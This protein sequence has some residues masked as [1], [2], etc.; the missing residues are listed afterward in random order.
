MHV[1]GKSCG[2]TETSIPGTF[3]GL[4]KLSPQ[5]L[6]NTSVGNLL[7][8][9]QGCEDLSYCGYSALS[10]DRAFLTNAIQNLHT[11]EVFLCHSFTWVRNALCFQ[12]THPKPAWEWPASRSC[13][14]HHRRGKSPNLEVQ[15]RRALG[16]PLCL[17]DKKSQ[18]VGRHCPW[19]RREKDC[20]GLAYQRESK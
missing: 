12:A 6:D 4:A 19:V 17:E 7:S 1:A 8:R 20:L 16:E 5:T 15:N 11:L 9:H 10:T 13:V 2:W 18:L 3:W 14:P